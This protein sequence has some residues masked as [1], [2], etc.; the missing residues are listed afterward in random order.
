M[1]HLSLGDLDARKR[2]QYVGSRL[3]GCCCGLRW[4][5]IDAIAVGLASVVHGGLKLLLRVSFPRRAAALL[6]DR[7]GYYRSSRI[8]NRLTY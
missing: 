1:S 2:V 7:Y 6:G 8:S 5:V 4:D 3:E